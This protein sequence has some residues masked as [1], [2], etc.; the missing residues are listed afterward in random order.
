MRVAGTVDEVAPLVAF[1]L[2]DDAS[3]ITG[4]EVPVDGGMTGH[5]GVTSISDAV[6]VS[7]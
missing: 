7:S 2:S 3:L 5:G 4:A 1:R 6:R